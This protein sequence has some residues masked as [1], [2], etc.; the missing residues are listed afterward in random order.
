MAFALQAEYFIHANSKPMAKI[1]MRDLKAWVDW[2]MLAPDTLRWTLTEPKASP[3]P[4]F[5]SLASGRDFHV[6]SC[7][8]LVT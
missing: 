5:L 8:K 6:F 3:Q 4:M 2:G 7:A 1:L